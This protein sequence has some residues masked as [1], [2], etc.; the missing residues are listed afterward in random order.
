MNEGGIAIQPDVNLQ[1]TEGCGDPCKKENRQ[2]GLILLKQRK[3]ASDT[4][5]RQELFPSH[6]LPVKPSVT[7]KTGL[8]DKL[9]KAVVRVIVT[10]GT[11]LTA[12]IGTN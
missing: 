5:G 9:R 11:E 8:E 3:N 2:C 12:T 1:N 4:L 7:V 6:Q 10:T